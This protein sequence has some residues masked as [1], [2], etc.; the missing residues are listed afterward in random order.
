[1]QLPY[2]P[3]GNQVLYYKLPDIEQAGREMNGS[4]TVYD[5]NSLNEKVTV[6]SLSLP[7]C[8]HCVSLTSA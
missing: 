3:E 5:F 2:N 4:D 7:E 1:M 8:P 6:I